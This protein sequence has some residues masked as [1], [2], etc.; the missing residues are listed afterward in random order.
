MVAQND[1]WIATILPPTPKLRIRGELPVALTIALLVHFGFFLF[2]HI[3]RSKEVDQPPTLVQLLTIPMSPP[4]PEAPTFVELQLQIPQPSPVAFPEISIEEPPA[5]SKTGTPSVSIAL[6]PQVTPAGG[7]GSGQGHGAG[8]G[9]AT[10]TWTTCTRRDMPDYPQSAKMYGITNAKVTLLVPLDERG[11]IGKIQV[12][13]SSGL[14]LLDDA[15]VKAVRRWKCSP[16]IEDG[17]PVKAI[18]KQ[19]IEFLLSR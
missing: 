11:A 17:R 3:G 2:L 13:R 16:V 6:P 5:V 19:E 7:G 8:Q 4:K 9:S 15:A 10:D 12:L 18:T 14:R 1:K